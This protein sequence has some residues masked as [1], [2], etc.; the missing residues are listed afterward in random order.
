MLAR[1]VIAVVVAAVILGGVYVFHLFMDVRA[2]SSALPG[3]AIVCSGSTRISSA[4]ACRA[5]GDA[6]LGEGP[7]SHTFNIEDLARLE[8]SRPLLGLAGA[9][10][11]DWFLGRYPDDAVW[12]EEVACSD[13]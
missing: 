3:V 10:E 11:A 6:I 12:A 7:P 4:E 2:T 13:R 8:L 9:C 1:V 5:W